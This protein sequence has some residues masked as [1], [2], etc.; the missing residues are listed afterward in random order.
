MNKCKRRARN[1]S[2]RREGLCDLSSGDVSRSG[3]V[4][5]GVRARLRHEVVDHWWGWGDWGGTSEGGWHGEGSKVGRAQ[6][7]TA[8]LLSCH[9]P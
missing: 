8:L 4:T 6:R 1:A 7:A 5:D 9:L 3:R 2:L